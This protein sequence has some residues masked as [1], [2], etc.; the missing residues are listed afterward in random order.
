M[1]TRISFPHTRI[2]NGLAVSILLVVFSGCVTTLGERAPLAATVANAETNLNAVQDAQ[3]KLTQNNTIHISDRAPTSV[4]SAQIPETSQPHSNTLPAPQQKREFN[5]RLENETPV[6]TSGLA[7]LNDIRVIG[8][9]TGS[10]GHPKAL[11]RQTE[12]P[13]VMFE[14]GQQLSHQGSNY[15]ITAIQNGA[16]IVKSTDNL[17]F[18]IHR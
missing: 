2:T 17:K 3:R 12:Q 1:R 10:D 6:P 13:A 18:I 11:L 8:S 4:A 5:L 7:A 14:L 9:I 16:V 15:E